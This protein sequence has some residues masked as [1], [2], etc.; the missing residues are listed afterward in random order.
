MTNSIALNSNQLQAIA[1]ILHI[2]YRK[3]QDA[4]VQ[5]FWKVYLVIVPGCR[6]TFVSKSGVEAK[7]TEIEQERRRQDAKLIWVNISGPNFAKALKVCRQSGAT[8][9]P[10]T[11]LWQIR[12]GAYDPSMMSQVTPTAAYEPEDCDWETNPRYGFAEA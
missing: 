2:G 3:I 12:W 1:K 4:T 5:A 8:Y 7:I 9:N 6:P 10:A 11:K